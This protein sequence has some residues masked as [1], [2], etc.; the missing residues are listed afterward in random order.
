DVCARHRA[1]GWHVQAVEDGNDVDAIG[2]AIQKARDERERP[3]LIAVRTVLGYGAPNKQGTFEAHG[4]P[5][6]ASEVRKTK[7]NLGWPLE[8]P[9]YVPEAARTHFRSAL[10]RGAE[11]ERE[12][13]AKLEAYE[14][15][16]P[17]L[18]R[19]LTRRFAS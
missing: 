9:F 5:L 18:A 12:F 10:E 7:Q 19:E 1:Y 6:G 13:Q 2:E 17:E 14:K 4:S 15:A 11:L 8:P 3:S 16:F